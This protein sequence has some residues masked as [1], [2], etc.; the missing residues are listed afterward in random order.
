MTGCTR[1]AI[2][3]GNVA[4]NDFGITS[5]KMII[6]TVKIA[7]ASPTLNPYGIASVVTSVGSK[8][9]AILLPI[10]IVVMNSFGLETIFKSFSDFSSP[11][12]AFVCNLILLVAVNAVSLP[13]KNNETNNKKMI[14]MI[15]SNFLL[16]K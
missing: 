5:E 2:R 9:F 1:T 10:K 12:A 11:F 13:E 8:I 7:E 14:A 3:S 16:V 15:T 6:V 4:A